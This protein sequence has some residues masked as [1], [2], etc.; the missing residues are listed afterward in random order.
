MR[1]VRAHLGPELHTAF[2]TIESSVTMPGWRS[3]ISWALVVTRP[4]DPPPDLMAV[5]LVH[6]GTSGTSGQTMGSSENNR[7]LVFATKT[8]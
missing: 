8:E 5:M 3:S 6:S 2:V 4:P 1:A 7:S